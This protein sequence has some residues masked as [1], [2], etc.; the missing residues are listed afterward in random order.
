MSVLGAGCGFPVPGDCEPTAFAVAAG[1]LLGDIGALSC[2][3]SPAVSVAI[4]IDLHE[5]CRVQA[6]STNEGRFL[7]LWKVIARIDIVRNKR[8]GRGRA[9]FFAVLE[10]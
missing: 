9:P 7:K 1:G 10:R 8:P 4:L 2:A 6:L 3:V 5:V